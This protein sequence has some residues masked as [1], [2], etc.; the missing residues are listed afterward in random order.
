MVARFKKLL[1]E[2]DREIKIY[3]KSIIKKNRTI[4]FLIREGYEK[5]LVL[6]YPNDVE[7]VSANFISEEEG[8]LGGF[9]NYKICPCNRENAN[10]LRKNFP[11]TRPRVIGLTPAIGCGD[12]IGLATP[13]HIRA[14]RKF[15][16]FPVLAQQSIREMTRT[17]RTPRDVLDDVSW[18]VFQ[19]G[20]KKGFASDAD[21]LKTEEDIKST[22]E[23]GFTMYT[24]D[25]SSFVDDEA[26]K[27][28]LKTL[29]EKFER[30]PWFDLNCD[31]EKFLDMYLGKEFIIE[32]GDN[33]FKISFTEENLIR[34]AVKYSA[35]IAHI[36]R[37]KRFLDRLFKDK[38]YDLEVS[39]DETE[40]PTKPLEHL[41]IA[42]ELKR[43]HINIQGLALRFVG[44]FEK[45]V[46]YIGDLKEFEETLRK[47]VLIA[48]KFGPY[49]LSIHSGSDKF[50][51]YP[52]LGKIAGD[53]IHLKTA[54]TSYL[55]SLRIIARHDPELFKE[56]IQYSIK[57]FEKDR[58]SYHISTK[59]S[60]VPS[61][62]K[63][64]DEELEK[65]YLDRNPGRQVLHVT[66]GSILTLKKGEKW[67]FRD[68]IR[69]VLLDNEEEYYET[70][71]KHI[72]RHIRGTF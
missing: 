65:V 13:G 34:A 29:K 4:F 39:I 25:P 28:D 58:A 63:V 10:E 23:A 15:N 69:K 16:V 56:I 30:I 14:V 33:S 1:K 37:L 49:K 47:H 70:I 45:A 60:M 38:K 5:K 44:L 8:K 40:S 51:I 62:E 48:K 41:F 22:F 24:L 36:L 53:M 46:D 7:G 43:L 21:H 50:S 9:W 52:I 67:I 27:D 26:D 57:C 71:S 3:R 59:L 17:A 35:A 18:S 64:S 54:G 6:L 72:E 12:R 61:V 32:D 31:K 68:R 20:Y 11:F 42:L 2:K 55:E 66:F 19:E